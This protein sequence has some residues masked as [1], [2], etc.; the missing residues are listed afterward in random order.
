LFRGIVKGEGSINNQGRY[1]F[2]LTAIDGKVSAGG[3]DR[4][5]IKIWDGNDNDRVGVTTSGARE[6]PATPR[7]R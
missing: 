5:R 6:T 4:F 1:A 3:P 7:P 2:L